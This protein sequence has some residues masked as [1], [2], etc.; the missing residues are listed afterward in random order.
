MHNKL[1][2]ILE[3]LSKTSST[4]AKVKILEENKNNEALRQYLNYATNKLITFGISDLPEYTLDTRVNGDNSDL[5]FILCDQLSRRVVTGNMARTAIINR[6]QHCS[7]LGNKWYRRAL[8]K[9]MSSIGLGRSLLDKAFGESK[10]FKL[11]LAEEPEALDKIPEDTQGYVDVKENGYRTTISFVDDKVDVIYSGRSGII[12]ENFYFLRE[13]LETLVKSF[14]DDIGASIVLD[15]E[16]HI[17]QDNHKVTSLYGFKWQTK[18]DF[19][20][21]SGKLKKRAW[22]TY[23]ARE[24]II[25][26]YREKAKFVIF[27]IIPIDAWNRQYYDKTIEHRKKHLEQINKFI[28]ELNLKQIEIVPTKIAKNKTEAIKIAQEYIDHGFEGGIFKPFG[29][30]YTWRRW[31]SWI[32][33]K[34]IVD[35]TVALTKYEIQKDKYNSDGSLKEPMACPIYGVDKFGNEHKI[36]TGDKSIFSEEIRIDMLKNWDTNYKGKLYD[37]EAQEPSK[38][39]HKYINPRLTRRRLDR[40]SLED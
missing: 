22:E 16:V 5:F 15:G 20:G 8:Q 1:F 9:D 17:D 6:L 14:P 4:N 21:K 39:S 38:V 19:I 30:M 29:E 7:E 25:L 40:S 3:E 2:E 31:R 11:G 34:R 32:K 24:A 26:E 18:E 23:K 36:G 27:D 37:C 35:F 33:I 10:K 28:K 13:E 12:A